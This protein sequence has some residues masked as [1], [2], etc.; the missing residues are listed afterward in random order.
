[1][2]KS[3]LLFCLGFSWRPCVRAFVG[4]L[5]PRGNAFQFGHSLFRQQDGRKRAVS[6]IAHREL[7]RTRVIR[8]LTHDDTVG[9]AITPDIF[10]NGC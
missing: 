6:V 8:T 3:E 9:E 10:P 7:D 5:L 2:N 1:M 4:V